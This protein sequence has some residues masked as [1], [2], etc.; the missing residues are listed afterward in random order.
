[1]KKSKT[2][3]FLSIFAAM[4]MLLSFAVPSR[5]QEGDE[6][7]YVSIGLF[8]MS[9]AV[10]EVVLK[11]PDGFIIAAAERSGFTETVD[12]RAYSYLK[13]RAQS[14]KVVVTAQDGTTLISA[15]SQSEAIISAAENPDERIVDING[16]KYR[17]G[18]LAG[19]YSSA[20]KLAV[21]NYISIEHYLWGV[22]PAEMPY[23]Y[24]DEAQ[25]AQAVAAR[26]YVL[27]HLGRHGGGAL[28]FDLCTKT[29]CQVYGAVAYERESSTEACR[30]SEG[31]VATHGGEIISAAYFAYDGGYT[32]NSEDLW[33]E[34]L[35]YLRGVRDEYTGSTK[36]NTSFTFEELRDRLD[37]AGYNI[38]RISSVSV[39]ER[40]ANGAVK[41][42][43]VKG[44]NRTANITKGNIIRI[45]NLKSLWFSLLSDGYADVSLPPGGVNADTPAGADV[46]Y[47]AGSSGISELS[48][49]IS[50]ISASGQSIVSVKDISIRD[51]SAYGEAPDYSAS[52][53]GQDEV[54][55]SSGFKDEICNKGIIYLSGIGWGHGVGLCQSGAFHMAAAGYDYIDILHYY[56]TDIDIVHLSETQF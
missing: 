28:S 34:I 25:K 6:D 46:V 4:L 20:D 52:E 26:S 38:G 32:L 23:F 35:P 11:S 31:L 21:A 37:A 55:E 29:H 49:D 18:V 36:W 19:A 13:L 10:S 41:A 16:K 50:L 7:F 1:M 24:P 30:A 8:Y 45:L 15:L 42:L 40:L 14:G 54:S 53:G 17:D 33:T 9:T 39:G 3:R 22:V 5:A 2:L 51:G 47:A 43:T 12:L 48:G 56:Y 44:S 27:S